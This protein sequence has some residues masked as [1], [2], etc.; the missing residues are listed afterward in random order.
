M[1]KKQKLLF[2]RTRFSADLNTMWLAGVGH[3]WIFWVC[4]T[5]LLSIFEARTSAFITSS[6]SQM[7]SLRLLP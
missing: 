5:L 2:G 1:Q 6:H 3:L 7:D 4:I